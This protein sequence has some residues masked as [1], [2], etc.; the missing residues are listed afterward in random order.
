MVDE[1]VISGAFNEKRI[2]TWVP[3]PQTT[4]GL[5]IISATSGMMTQN[6]KILFI[7]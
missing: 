5:Y 4:S 3:K 7:K 2:A 1:F 6:R